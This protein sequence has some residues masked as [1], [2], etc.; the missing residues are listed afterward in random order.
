MDG[1]QRKIQLELAFTTTTRGE[2]PK[3]V[4]EG[5]EPATAKSAIPPRRD[6][7]TTYGGGV[8]ARESEQGITEGQKQ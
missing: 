3:T 5:T 1:K 8:R 7:R 2:A 6:A 4:G